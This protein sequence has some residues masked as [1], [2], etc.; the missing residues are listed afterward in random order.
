MARGGPGGP[1]REMPG[2]R[3]AGFLVVSRPVVTEG[4][5]RHHLRQRPRRPRCSGNRGT[6]VGLPRPCSTPPSIRR[7]KG[8]TRASRCRTVFH[9]ERTNT[10]HTAGAPAH[11]APPSMRHQ[12]PGLDKPAVVGSQGVRP[13]NTPSAASDFGRKGRLDKKL[14]AV[15]GDQA[16][17]KGGRT[18][19][20]SGENLLCR[21]PVDLTGFREVRLD[22]HYRG[23]QTRD[24]QCLRYLDP[25]SGRP[26]S[27]SKPPLG[28][29]RG[30]DASCSRTSRGSGATY[31]PGP[32]AGLL[33]VN[34]GLHAWN[35]KTRSTNGQVLHAVVPARLQGA[36]VD[37]Q[38]RGFHAQRQLQ[39]NEEEKRYR[40]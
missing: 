5:T 33:E 23:R 34:G 14:E 18:S 21:F 10:K 15:D 2:I 19:G 8:F 12:R 40:M 4:S 39:G 38:M 36:G 1:S 35:A 13:P 37:A 29:E 30:C 22:W 25:R 20:T 9:V 7:D 31:F 3:R 27:P 16:A 26:R 17:A 32:T 6:S 24:E 28:T 11:P